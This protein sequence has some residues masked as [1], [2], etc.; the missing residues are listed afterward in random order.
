M[1]KVTVHK[2]AETIPGRKLYEEIRYSRGNIIEGIK[3]IWHPTTD[4]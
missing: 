4:Y 2:N 3:E 1:P